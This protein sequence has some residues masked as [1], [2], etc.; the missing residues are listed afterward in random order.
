LKISII[1]VCYNSS[2]YI[3]S[4]VESVSYQSYP[5]LEYIVIDGGSTDGT[6]DILYEYKYLISHLISEPDKGIYD[7]MNKGLALVTGDVVGILNSDDFY[8]DSNVLIC[9]ASMFNQNPDVDMVLGNVDFVLPDD[10]NKRVRFYSS[11]NFL[12]WKF[13]FGLMPAHP[14]AFIKKSAYE[15]VGQYKL[16]YKI[17]ADFDM[18]IRLCLVNQCTFEKLN[19]SLVRM[20]MGGISTAGLG[21][22]L[23]ATNEMVRALKE[24]SVYSNKFLVSLRLPVKLAQL[25]MVKLG[26]R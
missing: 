23:I 16:G 14:G 15:R 21:S 8:P 12:P 3:R 24:N 25:L 9:V 13:R 26:I 5:N 18:F 17:A 10:L 22:N 2:E 6:L 1:T 7:A 11:V 20:R 19:K 4:A